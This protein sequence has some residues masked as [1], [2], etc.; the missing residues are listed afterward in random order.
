[1]WQYIMLFHS[2]DMECEFGEV[3]KMNGF[4]PITHLKPG[5]CAVI[6]A[7]ISKSTIR[8][9][10]LDLGMIEGTK[11]ECVLKSPCGDPIAYCVRGAVIALR[12]EDSDCIIVDKL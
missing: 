10:L 12:N 9:R 3:I 4:Y 1:L 6:K 8:K 7:L 11:I 2:I 5:E